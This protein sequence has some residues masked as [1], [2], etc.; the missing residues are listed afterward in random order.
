MIN[1]DVH[2]TYGEYRGKCLVCKRLLKKE[3]NKVK[4]SKND[5]VNIHMIKCIQIVCSFVV[6]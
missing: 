3:T 2:I 6:L 1:D 4:K 5:R